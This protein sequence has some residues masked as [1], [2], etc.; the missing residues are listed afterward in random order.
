M[1]TFAKS[2][3]SKLMLLKRKILQKI[4]SP[5]INEENDYKIISNWELNT[6]LTSPI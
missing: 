1:E 5:E 4:F 6:L 3:K 2:D